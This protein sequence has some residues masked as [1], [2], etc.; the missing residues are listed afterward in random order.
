MFAGAGY[1][2]ATFGTV[3]TLYWITAAKVR[4]PGLR[5]AAP[6]GFGFVVWFRVKSFR[7]D[8][9][10]TPLRLPGVV[11]GE[12]SARGVFWKVGSS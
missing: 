9:N 2:Y 4:R 8:L 11:K 10:P 7:V 6:L 1:V 3:A 5:F 12:A